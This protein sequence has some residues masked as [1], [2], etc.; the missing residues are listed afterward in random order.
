[1]SNNVKDMTAGKPAKLIFLFSMP[2][3]A[4]NIFQQLYTVVDTMVIGKGLGVEA[5]AA[6]GAIDWFNWMNLGIV[7]GFTQGFGVLIAQKYGEKNYKNLKEILADSILLSAV[8]SV[9][10]IALMELAVNPAL[11][12]LHVPTAIQGYSRLYLR[13]IFAGIPIMMAYNM[14]SVILR[15]L[16]DSKTPLIAMVIA[17]ISNI[18]LDILMVIGLHM[19]VAG[20]AIATL[21]GQMISVV[22]CYIKYKKIE[23]AKFQKGEFTLFPQWNLTLFKLGTPMA[24]QNMIIAVGG[25]VLQ[26]IVDRYGVVFIAG[27]TATNKMY[28]ILE[29][30]GIAYGYAMVTY[31]GQNLGARKL[32]RIRTGLRSSLLIAIASCLLISTCMIIFGKNILALFIS[33]SE[34]DVASALDYAYDFLRLMSI[35][36]PVL[37]VLHIIRST[38]QGMGRTFAAMASGIFE[39]IMRVGS[40]IMLPVYFGER[41]LFWAEILAWTAADVVLISGYFIAIRAEKRKLL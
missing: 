27:F 26:S 17:T 10:L 2:L 33:G 1:M 11:V 4:G 29:C 31:V 19:G 8:I 32:D 28:G 14:L 13:I 24:F 9:L 41:G 20:A 7:Q 37:Y 15:S 38:L 16:G 39:L 18:I 22:F 21:M 5:L 34:T 12:I 30:A 25:I 40:A 36:L 35:F 3:L 23:I 6:M